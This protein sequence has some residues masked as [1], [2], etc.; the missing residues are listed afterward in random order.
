MLKLIQYHVNEQAWSQFSKL[1]QEMINYLN[2]SNPT[3]E[4]YVKRGK[5][6]GISIVNEQAF[7]RLT[8]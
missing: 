5:E 4:E 3:F 1:H 8:S 6:L 7:I 2:I